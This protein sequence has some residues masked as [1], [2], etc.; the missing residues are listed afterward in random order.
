MPTRTRLDMLHDKKEVEST[1]SY[2]RPFS[3][4]HLLINVH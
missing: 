4:G 3:L 2:A 1:R